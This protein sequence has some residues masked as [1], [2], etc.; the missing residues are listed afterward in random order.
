MIIILAQYEVCFI[1]KHGA[2][3]LYTPL[4]KLTKFE[5]SMD[6]GIH[7]NGAGA[8][9]AKF[10]QS[11]V[12]IYDIA[13]GSVTAIRHPVVSLQFVINGRIFNEFY[14]TWSTASTLAPMLLRHGVIFHSRNIVSIQKYSL[15]VP[16]F[17]CYLT[18][19]PFKQDFLHKVTAEWTQ[20][21]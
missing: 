8:T 17:C 20:W 15:I 16:I 21:R 9:H 18:L 10:L 19:N 1:Q 11:W 2:L 4:C 13:E 12:K 5:T 7:E 6:T 14:S 3:L